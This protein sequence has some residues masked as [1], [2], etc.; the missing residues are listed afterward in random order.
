MS[1]IVLVT[2][3]IS[4]SKCGDQ[5]P[6]CPWFPLEDGV[7]MP[8]FPH[9]GRIND[10]WFGANGTVLDESFR[11]ATWFAFLD[12]PT[13]AR[14]DNTVMPSYWIEADSDVAGLGVCFV[15]CFWTKKLLAC[16]GCRKGF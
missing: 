7:E 9:S 8:D 4:Y 13:V 3:G 11:T 15:S 16:S 6:F 14:P 2:M 12:Q 1:Q 10:T 5:K